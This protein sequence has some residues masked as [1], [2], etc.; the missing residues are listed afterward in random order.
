ML[1]TNTK[2]IKLQILPKAE[3]VN[4][5]QNLQKKGG[6]LRSILGQEK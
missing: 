4:R 3:I 1:L 5:E 2:K 6:V